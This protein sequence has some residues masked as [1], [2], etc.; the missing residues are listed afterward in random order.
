[1][2]LNIRNVDPDL[3]RK[4]KV[5]CA[6]DGM[7]I[8]DIAQHMLQQGLQRMDEIFSTSEEPSRPVGGLDQ[9][10]PLRRA[11]VQALINTNLKPDMQSLEDRKA[12]ALAA[13]AQ[14]EKVFGSEIFA[15]RSIQVSPYKY[16][17]TGVE[18]PICGFKWWEEGANFEC[19]MDK[20]HKIPKHGQRG[21]VRRLDD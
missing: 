17:D 7:T 16:I 3:M 10:Q 18:V 5:R 20:G 1:M 13:M 14:A 12:I 19:L 11:E 8:R 2:D 6:E 4:L 21:M 9:L 15:D